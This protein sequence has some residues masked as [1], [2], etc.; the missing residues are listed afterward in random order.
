MC[1]GSVATW[2]VL[3]LQMRHLF[4]ILDTSR[5]MDIQDLKPNRMKCTVEVNL[6][7]VCV[8]NGVITTNWLKRSPRNP[9][10]W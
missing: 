6:K 4:L 1:H 10:V 9:I 2:I 5:A 8:N 3:S 7:N